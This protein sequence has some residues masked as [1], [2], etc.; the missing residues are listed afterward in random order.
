[1]R[2]IGLSEVRG[3]RE[4]APAWAGRIFVWVSYLRR[5]VRCT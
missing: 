1:L 4:L 3:K 5:G 2:V